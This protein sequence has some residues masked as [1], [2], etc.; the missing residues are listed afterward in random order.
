VLLVG[1]KVGGNVGSLVVGLLVG[2]NVGRNVGSLVV[3]LLVV[4]VVVGAGVGRS[5]FPT[6]MLLGATEIT[7]V[8]EFSPPKLLAL[9]F[10]APPSLFRVTKRPVITARPATIA[11]TTA[12]APNSIHFF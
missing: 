1:G 6:G 7:P 2:G 12:I 9:V 3:G 5:S 11:T 8:S 10:S 4:L